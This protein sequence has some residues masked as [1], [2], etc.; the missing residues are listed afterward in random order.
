MLLKIKLFNNSM[1]NLI[2]NYLK[3]CLATFLRHFFEKIGVIECISKV[4]LNSTENKKPLIKS[5]VSYWCPEPESNRHTHKARDF[6][7]LVSTNFTTRAD[8]SCRTNN[9]A[10]SITIHENIAVIFKDFCNY[11][12]ILTFK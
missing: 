7:S 11:F 6:K 1:R 3:F 2:F 10:Y 4:Y 12:I 5:G 8:G 9:G